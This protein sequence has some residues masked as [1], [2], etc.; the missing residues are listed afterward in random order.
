MQPVTFA[1]ETMA[2]PLEQA[3]GHQYLV[4]QVGSHRLGFPARWVDCLL[5]LERRQILPLPFYPPAMLG[6]VRHQGQL[7]PLV[8]LQHLLDE[9]VG[10]LPEVFNG[11]QLNA[12]SGVA[13]VGLAIDRILGNFGEEQMAADATIQPFQLQWLNEALF[14]PQRWKPLPH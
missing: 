5:L 10:P 11:L 8:R 4:T 3:P 12:S 7:V 1:A 13:G 2:A 9:A 14:E 6:V